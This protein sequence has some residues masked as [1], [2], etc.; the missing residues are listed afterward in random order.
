MDPNDTLQ[1]FVVETLEAS[2]SYFVANHWYQ[3][4]PFLHVLV[5]PSRELV[6]SHDCCSLLTPFQTLGS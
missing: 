4:S 6:C 5:L 1:N 2:L 3:A